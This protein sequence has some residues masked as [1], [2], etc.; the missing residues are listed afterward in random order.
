MESHAPIRAELNAKL[1]VDDCVVRGPVADLQGERADGLDG[2][3][4]H[5]RV[6][7]DRDEIRRRPTVD[8]N[9]GE[10]SESR[11]TDADNLASV[12]TK[13]VLVGEEYS[14]AKVKPADSVDGW[15]GNDRKDRRGKGGPHPV[16]DLDP[17]QSTLLR[18]V[19]E[20][21][22]EEGQLFLRLA[23]HG[24]RRTATDQ[25]RRRGVEVVPSDGDLL[26]TTPCHEV[27]VDRV[28]PRRSAVTC[29]E[30]ERLIVCKGSTPK[31]GKEL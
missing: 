8:P 17:D 18:G 25:N 12:V 27:G 20:L 21:R 26:S 14:G 6:G 11:T 5:E 16:A 23:D 10:R 13:Q 31:V 30:P 2:R 28:D 29:D 7:V 1:L 24:G 22:H 3:V 4:E 19:W 15:V 9:R